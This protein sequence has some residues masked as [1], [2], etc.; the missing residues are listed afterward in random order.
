MSITADDA[1]VNQIIHLDVGAMLTTIKQ[2]E[3]CVTSFK[4]KEIN[5]ELIENIISRLENLESRSYLSTENVYAER[6]RGDGVDRMVA[7][8][9]F[10]EKIKNEFESKIFSLR[11]YY[12]SKL[13]ASQFEVERL[14]KLL[15]IRPTTTEMQQVVLNI[16]QVENRVQSSVA[17]I[18]GVIRGTVQQLVAEE[19]MVIIDRMKANENL[20]EKSVHLILQKTE[21]TFHELKRVKENMKAIVDES[22]QEVDT[23]KEEVNVQQLALGSITRR[24]HDLEA[25]VKSAIEDL[26]RTHL[27]LQAVV[28]E[29]DA[30]LSQKIDCLDLEINRLG[31][32]VKFQ[33]EICG[34]Q[35]EN[36]LQ[37]LLVIKSDIS[38]FKNETE[39]QFDEVKRAQQ[40]L[41]ESFKSVLN[42]Q[43]KIVEFVDTWRN[44]DINAKIEQL[45]TSIGSVA[46]DVN[47]VD[48]E[49]NNLRIQLM[50]QRNDVIDLKTCVDE[51]PAKIRETDNKCLTNL[52]DLKKT[53]DLL[54]VVRSAVQD[55]AQQIKE[56]DAI[57]EDIQILK[58]VGS[59]HDERLKKIQRKI[60]D[61]AE[62][63]CT[64]DKKF[65]EFESQISK[66]NDENFVSIQALKG[67]LETVTFTQCGLL[68][69]ALN[70][71]KETVSCLLANQPKP[72]G[73]ISKMNS[74]SKDPSSDPN[75][76]FKP[77]G[78]IEL[79]SKVAN[80]EERQ[81]SDNSEYLEHLIEMCTN[82]EE[83]AMFR[84]IVPKDMPKSLSSEMAT[85]VTGIA[86][87][88]STAVDIEAIQ[89]LLS[90]NADDVMYDDN[91]Q[92]LRVEKIK[93]FLLTLQ[94]QLKASSPSTG[95]LRMETR[96]L[97][98]S[99]LSHALQLA[100]SK[101]DQV[102]TTGYSRLGRI[103]IPACI[104]C[105]RPL[106]SR[107]RQDTSRNNDS[108]DMNASNSRR[109]LQSLSMNNSLD[110]SS[111]LENSILTK[112]GND[113]VFRHVLTESQELRLSKTA[114][115]CLPSTGTDAMKL[116]NKAGYV[117]RGGFKMPRHAASAYKLPDI[118]D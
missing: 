91:Q 73:A 5:P 24:H 76:I 82:F 30:T 95:A 36:L 27:G 79:K 97:F 29:N 88:L 1:R 80:T 72:K 35:C 64:N 51:I 3:D 101:Y 13:S 98:L 113:E 48:E 86:Q 2:L 58:D 16:N 34:K 43:E 93:Q 61:H 21:E 89:R 11:M 87:H 44:F 100:I 45:Q 23:M 106:I 118:S 38:S 68:S 39:L 116:S 63:Q 67:E 32:N 105:D 109:G 59:T 28:N 42:S 112:S 103:K 33:G 17:S 90:N 50:T 83:L 69:E 62:V 74:L 14:H 77:T 84:G 31:D 71:L 60:I 92:D 94:V 65:V 10:L 85:I 115:V 12:E 46:K 56:V 22:R 47:V 41:Q 52:Q 55:C 75:D 7:E 57:K 96:D 99:R 26:E 78:L 6:L 107:G 117:L 114:N 49:L 81:V 8:D 102:V 53:N 66:Y 104:A 70:S 37:E 110:N 111:L 54:E 19:M 18:P 4:K 15:E 40:K 9:V 20:G 108:I 25:H